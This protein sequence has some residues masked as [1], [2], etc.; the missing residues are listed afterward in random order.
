MKLRWPD[1]PTVGP[2]RNGAFR[3]RLHNEQTA[4]VLGIALGIGFVVCFTTGLISHLVQN[5]PDWFLWTSRPAGLYR[6]TQGTHVV[7][8][9]A[10]IPVL[11]AKLWVV[12]PRLFEWPP[13]DS[14]A[15]LIERLMIIPLVGGGL[16]LVFTGLGNI[17]VWRPWG[18]GFR[19]GHYWAAWITIG[20]L[21]VHA[22]AKYAT[23]L[24]AL[25]RSG[26]SP[27]G[28]ATSPLRAGVDPT[29][30]DAGLSRR[31]FFATTFGAAG[32]IALFS[33][34]QTFTPLSRAALIVPRRSDVGPQGLPV[35]R[36]ASSVGLSD[37]DPATY[38]LTVDGSGATRPFTL[39]YDDLLSMPQRTVELP[40]ACVEGWSANATWR[41]V[42]VTDLLER[43]G[44]PDDCDARVTSMQDSPR[45][46]SSD[47]NRLHAH[48][49][50]TLLALELNGETLDADHGFPLR[51]IGPNRP[52]VMQTKWV[53]RLEA[54]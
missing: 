15:Q 38:T 7:V 23:T 19:P 12:Y 29:G 9:L 46:R 18:F 6:V 4:A 45:Q 32:A 52:G 35:N 36:T 1:R 39:S 41:G 16:F 34:G 24:E 20:A 10:L 25:R 47:L 2:F 5:P 30:D 40:I 49:P 42:A 22:F 14:A 3:P 11:L 33:V 31:G 26:T 21:V 51:L 17:N 54:L 53:S 8:G 28:D 44:A 13:F 37:V 48:D 43:A 27:V 50:D